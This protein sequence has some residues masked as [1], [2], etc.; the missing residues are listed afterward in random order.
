MIKEKNIKIKSKYEKNQSE[1]IVGGWIGYS[2]FLILIDKNQIFSRLIKK[3]ERKSVK[4]GYS[5]SL[6]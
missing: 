6:S 3:R 4:N 2:F 1:K 5:F